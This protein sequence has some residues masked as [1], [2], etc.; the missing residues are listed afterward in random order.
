MTLP[1]FDLY[2][3]KNLDDALSFY[4]EN[5]DATKIIAG[6]TDI[7][8]SLKQKLFEP[9]FLLDLKAIPELHGI[10]EEANGSVRIGAMTTISEIARSPFL[11]REFPVLSSAAATVAGPCLRNVGTLGGN[12]CLDTRCYWYN[13]SYFWRQSCGFC[14]KKDGTLC[15]VAP[16]SKTCWAV[17]SG[18]TAAAL[19]TLN[20]SLLI[21]SAD[22]QR[23]VSV[24]DFF[25]NDGAVRNRLNPGEILVEV[26]IPSEARGYAGHYEKFRL[27]GSV[28][29]PLA[30]VAVALK[31]NGSHKGAGRLPALEDLRVALTAVNPLPILL[32]D[33]LR[34]LRA[35]SVAGLQKLAKRTAKPLKT[36]AST[37]E[38]RRYMI[39]FMIKKAMEKLTND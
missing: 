38:Y 36:S 2:I 18:D 26:H 16:G 34:E 8:P 3:P 33:P 9:K 6:G 14:I 1:A 11:R 31:K 30:G 29:Y 19:L 32:S 7:V 24:S 25:V 20:G 15:H 35:D 10:H 39:E 21:A 28:D 27:R 4:T 23:S 13:Q 17:Y 5:L 12:I 37:M 22:G